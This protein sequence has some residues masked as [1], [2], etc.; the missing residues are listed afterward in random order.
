MTWWGMCPGAIHY[1]GTIDSRDME[2]KTVHIDGDHDLYSEEAVIKE[3]RRWFRKN[4]KRGDIMLLGGAA[5]RDPQK[6]LCGPAE[7][8]KKGNALYAKA[9]AIDFWEKD[10]ARMQ[11]LSDQWDVLIEKYGTSHKAK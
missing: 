3:A 7:F 1:F 4:A 2:M 5:Y 8:K 9:E 6:V 10:E 11:K